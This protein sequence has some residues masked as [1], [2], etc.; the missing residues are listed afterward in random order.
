[1]YPK[2]DIDDLRPRHLVGEDTP[3]IVAP[4]VTIGFLAFCAADAV[5]GGWNGVSAFLAGTGISYALLGF[6][7]I[8]QSLLNQRQN[9][10]KE[11]S[12]IERRLDLIGTRIQEKGSTV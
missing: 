3:N 1:M 2:T 7:L 10:E 6:L 8:V 4:S 12:R 9:Y 5:S 11:L